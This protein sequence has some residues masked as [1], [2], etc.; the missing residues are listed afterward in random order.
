[1]GQ[2][3]KYV[4]FYLQSKKIIRISICLSYHHIDDITFIPSNEYL[5]QETWLQQGRKITQFHLIY[6]IFTSIT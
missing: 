6:S 4:S 5:R 1:M 3:K 2:K